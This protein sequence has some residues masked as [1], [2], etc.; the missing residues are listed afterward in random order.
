MKVVLHQ[1]QQFND[2]LFVGKED[3]T[4]WPTDLAKSFV[5]IPKIEKALMIRNS[6]DATAKD[7]KDLLLTKYHEDLPF[8]NPTLS[9]KGA[10]LTEETLSRLTIFSLI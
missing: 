6:S 5:L 7:L 3:K 1:S 4:S 2:V 9:H 10:I 8:V